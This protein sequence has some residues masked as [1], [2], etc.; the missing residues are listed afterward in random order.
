[1]ETQ[2]N[3]L[4]TYLSIQLRFKLGVLQKVI[5]KTCVSHDKERS[6]RKQESELQQSE[7]W[8]RDTVSLP[9]KGQ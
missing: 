7:S 8:V 9:W 4:S 3:D 1:M 2:L 6:Y 5:L